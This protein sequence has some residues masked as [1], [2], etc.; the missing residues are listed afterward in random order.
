VVVL[1]VKLAIAAEQGFRF[2]AFDHVTTAATTAV[3][4]VGEAEKTLVA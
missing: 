1:N 3:A 2:G 4:D